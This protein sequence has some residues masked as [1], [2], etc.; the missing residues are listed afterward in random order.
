MKHS[1]FYTNAD[2]STYSANELHNMLNFAYAEMANMAEGSAQR[3][4]AILAIQRIT[5]AL[6]QVVSHPAPAP[7]FNF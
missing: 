4:L 3:F 1:K 6:S 2:L 7:K 5:A